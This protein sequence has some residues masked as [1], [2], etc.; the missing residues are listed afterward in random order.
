[1]MNGGDPMK[2]PH[3]VPDRQRELFENLSAVCHGFS[4]AEVMVA[5]INLMCNTIR[6]SAPHRDRAERMF[7]EAAGKAKQVL[8]ERHYH[9]DGSR[10]N[11]FPH[12]QIIEMGPPDKRPFRK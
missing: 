9:G 6:Q 4:G 3:L 8:L 10:R 5:S 1:M 2:N 12:T 7:D 11:I